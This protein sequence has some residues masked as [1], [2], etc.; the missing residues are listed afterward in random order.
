[1]DDL[2]IIPGKLTIDDIQRL[3]END[4]QIALDSSCWGKITEAQEFVKKI[5]DKNQTVYGINTGFG[6]L[7]NTSIPI[8]DLISLQRRIL[9][10]HAAGIG[11][12]LPDDIVKLILLFKINSLARGYSGIRRVVIET[13]VQFFNHGIYPCIPAKGSVGASGDLAP[14][15]HMSLPL[16]GEGTVRYKGQIITGKAGLQLIGMNPIELAPKEGLALINGTHVSTAI[17]FFH[18]LKAQELL[19]A[20]LA[21]GALTVD[22]ALGCDTAFQP[23]IHE[24]RGQVGQIEVARVLLEYLTGSEIRASH[25][26]CERV[27]DPYCLRC[28]PEVIG[29][30]LDNIRHVEKILMIEVNAVTGAS[31]L[32]FTEIDSVFS[33]GNFHAEPVAQAADLLAIALSEV[34]AI[35]ERRN[36]AFSRSK[37]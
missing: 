33:G 31:F 29:A 20:S 6:L 37:L 5:V 19:S 4:I 12:L 8:N 21:I 25:E 14:L 3:S 35:A 2:N 16:M 30:S 22:A 13:L 1:M 32:I 24:V 18:C 11:E 17:A 27:Q 15:S 34:G 23:Q 9:L 26:N 28:M 10:S 7:A 36:C